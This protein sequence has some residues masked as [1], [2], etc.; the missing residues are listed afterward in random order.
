MKSRTTV[1]TT[2]AA[3]VL[4]VPLAAWL[5]AAGAHNDRDT[6]SERGNELVWPPAPERPRIRF[7]SSF[8]SP[9]DLKL[10]RQSFFKTLI[11]KVIGIDERDPHMVYPYGLTTDSQ[12]RLIAVD[13]KLRLVHV[14]DL[15]Q[16]R[17]MA[18]RP[19]NKE[20]FVS[21]IGVALDAK[22]NIYVSDSYEGKIFIFD[23]EGKLKD[24]IGQPEGIFKRPTGLA[25]DKAEG[26]LYVVDTLRDEVLAMDLQ[27]HRLFRFGKPG[28]RNGEF[29]A[30]TQICFHEGKLFVTD[31]LNARIQEF[32]THGNFLFASGRVG[33]GPGDLDK[34]KGVA[35]DSE[36]HVYVVEGLHDL[37]QIFD[38]QGRFL[39]AF[40]GT[41]SQKGEFYLPT[42]IHIDAEDNIYVA[43]SYNSRIQVFKYLKEGDG[44]IR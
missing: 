21:P 37:V 16:K 43:D 24:V 10:K 15:K 23:R 32:D 40:G 38:T 39:L 12:G 3:V 27:G 26:R 7:L 19:P 5:T 41:G 13:S 44:S 28:E 6:R 1:I 2:I 18:I 34:P 14:F 42:A 8:A 33:D 4:C 29:N 20:R 17:Y 9:K 30:P 11:K 25:I 36:G 31:T 22:D 35:V